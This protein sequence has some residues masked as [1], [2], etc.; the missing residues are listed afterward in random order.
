MGPAAFSQTGWL[1]RW[2]KS[3]E[4]DA[5]RE[6]KKSGHVRLSRDLQELRN[7]EKVLRW[8]L[9]YDGGHLNPAQISKK[10]PVVRRLSPNHQH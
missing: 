8:D 4:G 2:V 3:D 6:R 9:S 5:Q 10:L 1:T 7:S